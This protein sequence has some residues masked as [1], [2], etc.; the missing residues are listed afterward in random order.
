[1]VNQAVARTSLVDGQNGRHG[2]R[3]RGV[4]SS[5][6]GAVRRTGRGR[7]AGCGLRTNMKKDKRVKRKQR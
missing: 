6:R 1:M 2:R 3:G 4:P 5:G 7:G